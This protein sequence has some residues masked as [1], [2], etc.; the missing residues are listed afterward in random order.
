MSVEAPERRS[1]QT[2]GSFFPSNEEYEKL[3]G[4][5]NRRGLLVK[6]F[7]LAALATAVLALVVLLYTIINDSFGLVAVVNQNEPEDVVASFG[8]DPVEVGLEDLEYDQ[9]VEAL[10]GGIETNEE[11]STT[12]RKRMTVAMSLWST[13]DGTAAAT[14]RNGR[15]GAIAKSW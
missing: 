6:M 7:F 1:N 11:T 15:P 12:A 14:R 3:L 13:A 2:S 4:R 5:K 8:Y 10:A 9:L